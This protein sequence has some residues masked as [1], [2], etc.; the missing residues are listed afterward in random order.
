MAVVWPPPSPW[1]CSSTW[2]CTRNR[3]PGSYA[4]L[5]VV[6]GVLVAVRLVTALW[7]WERLTAAGVSLAAR[8]RGAG[9]A[10]S[11]VAD[12]AGVGF[13]GRSR[14]GGPP[15]LRRGGRR[16][17]A[18]GRGLA[19]PD[20]RHPGR[21]AQGVPACVGQDRQAPY[22]LVVLYRPVAE[23]S[24]S[25]DTP[26]VFVPGR[27]SAR[28]AEA[29]FDGQVIARWVEG[30]GDGG[31]ERHRHRRRRRAWN[32]RSAPSCSTACGSG[33]WSMCGSS[34]TR[35]SCSN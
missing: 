28:S 22:R 1:A 9:R 5:A 24:R 26:I 32:S 31:R 11:P 33:T 17:G 18:G 16:T 27:R 34:R 12:L 3:T 21:A 20:H 10:D 25:P 35:G 8:W 6:L 7:R 29:R 13:T 19:G 4:A 2:P 23:A 30:D 15:G 14:F